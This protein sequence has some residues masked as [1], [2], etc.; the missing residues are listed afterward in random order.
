MSQPRRTLTRPIKDMI[1]VRQLGQ[2]A[3]C[4]SQL[5]ESF[6]VDHLSQCRDD[7]RY[8]NLVATCGTCHNEKSLCHQKRRYGKVQQMINTAVENRELILR[9]HIL[10]GAPIVWPQWLSGRAAKTTLALMDGISNTGMLP[11]VASMK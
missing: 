8:Q 6:E 5:L 11:V 10:E 4:L 1:F 3:Y 7:N 2:C 9:S